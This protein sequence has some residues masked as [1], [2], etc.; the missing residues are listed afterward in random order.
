MEEKEQKIKRVK[1][2]MNKQCPDLMLRPTIFESVKKFPTD[3]KDT[4]TESKPLF[5]GCLLNAMQGCALAAEPEGGIAKKV[6]CFDLSTDAV[7]DIPPYQ[8]PEGL[9]LQRSRLSAAI[10]A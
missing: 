1:L 8:D 7:V 2:F 5:D 9:M 3:A 10:C 4:F 6:T